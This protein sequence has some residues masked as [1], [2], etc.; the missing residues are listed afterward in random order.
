M[1]ISRLI[2]SSAKTKML[3]QVFSKLDKSGNPRN[4]I[5]LLGSLFLI[6]CLIQ[7]F[8]PDIVELGLITVSA[9]FV[10][11]YVISIAAYLKLNSNLKNLILPISL[12]VAFLVSFL[13]SG[14]SIL[15][16]ISIFVISYLISKARG[17]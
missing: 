7:L 3:P 15:Y 4:A 16:T 8:N 17:I 12:F 10:F 11:I 14:I 5:I 9:N 13:F 2:M 1:G 6:T